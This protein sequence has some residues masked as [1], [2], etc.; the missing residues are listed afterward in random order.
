MAVLALAA[1]LG[2]TAIA[3]TAANSAPVLPSPLRYVSSLDLE[4]FRTTPYQPPPLPAPLTLSHLNP[5]LAGQA[6]WTVAGLGP[7]TQLCSPVAKNGNIPSED[8]LDFIRYTDLSCYR[9][10]GPNIDFD[11]KL[12]HLNPVFAN[13]PDR[14]VTLQAPDQLCVPVIKGDEQPPDEVLRFVRYIDLACFRE[15]PQVPLGTSVK[16]TQLNKALSALPPTKVDVRENRQLCV[17]VRKNAQKIPDDV[18]KI[19]QYIDL[20]KFDIAAPAMAPIDLRLTHINPLLA[21]LPVEPA[22][23]LA[24]EQLAVP[25]AKNGNIPLG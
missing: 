2:G 13:L 17:P 22:R 6:P 8:V 20:E 4:C 18:L 1:A 10:G 24:R 9:I 15:T 23:L 5:V 7:R 19:V 3:T 12:H 16:L 11:V 14:K 21:G 25:V